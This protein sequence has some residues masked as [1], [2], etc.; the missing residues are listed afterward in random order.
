MHSSINHS[1][2]VKTIRYY[3]SMVLYIHGNEGYF[4]HCVQA[5]LKEFVTGRLV[6]GKTQR[7]ERDGVL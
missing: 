1:D 7:R 3:Q 5:A 6:V 4:H 2:S